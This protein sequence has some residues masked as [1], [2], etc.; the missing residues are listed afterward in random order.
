MTV[1]SSANPS[2]LVDQ[3][4]VRPLPGLEIDD[5]RLKVYGISYQRDEPGADLIAAAR[6]I[7]VTALPQGARDEGRHGVGFLIAHDGAL[8]RWALVYWWSNNV[9]FHERLFH[10][11]V[12]SPRLELRPVTDGLIA[13]VYEL[14][15]VE[16]ERQ[17]WLRHVIDGPGDVEA[18]L[19]DQLT[20]Q[21]ALG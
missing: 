14:R 20:A 13:C 15:V 18:Y 1:A 19:A 4:L 8:G 5:W 11:P 7:A 6:E 12:D 9:W 2:S 3:R 17:A 21:P 10:S 16:W